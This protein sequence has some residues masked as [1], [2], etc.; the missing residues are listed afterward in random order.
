[1]KDARVLVAGGA[2]FIGSQLVR[3][4]LR[5]GARVLVFDNLQTGCIENL[6]GLSSQRLQLEV[7]DLLDPWTI[8]TALGRFRPNLVYNLAAETF[9]PS[10]FRAPFRFLRVNVEGHLNLLLACR[11]SGVERV[12]YA[13]SAEVYGNP[14]PVPLTEE[15]PLGAANSYAATKLAADRLSFTLGAEHGIP[16]AI[17]RLFNAYG[18][19]ETERYVIPEIIAQLHEG[20]PLRLGNLGARRDF[21][22]VDDTARALVAL[23]DRRVPADVPVNVGSNHAHDI[24]DVAT[25]LAA[26]MGRRLELEVDDS[27]LRPND[28]EHLQADNTRLRALTGWAPQVGLQE[29]LER[30][31]AWFLDNGGRWPWQDRVL[32]PTAEIGNAGRSGQLRDIGGTERNNRAAR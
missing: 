7:G 5:A 15:H 30:T 6:E 26:I 27:R 3:E 21:T 22:Y 18:P 20:G 13:S 12:V 24:R 2:G 32:N 29:G 25:R 16:V 17:A 19:R 31:V 9:I 10:V 28:I 4:L 11:G 8:Q 1:M 14:E 23:G